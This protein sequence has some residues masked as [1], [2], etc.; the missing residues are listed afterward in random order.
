MA[1][2]AQC[3]GITNGTHCSAMTNTGSAPRRSRAAASLVL[4]GRGAGR[5]RHDPGAPGHKTSMEPGREACGVGKRRG[6]RQQPG[7]SSRG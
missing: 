5:V 3:S 2:E 1:P 7:S 4:R 6:A